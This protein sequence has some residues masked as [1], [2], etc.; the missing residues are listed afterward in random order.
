MIVTIHILMIPF[1]LIVASGVVSKYHRSV[2]SVDSPLH[3]G[4][5]LH[6]LIREE[7]LAS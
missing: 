6:T 4:D 7:V 2:M 3:F 1:S 5:F